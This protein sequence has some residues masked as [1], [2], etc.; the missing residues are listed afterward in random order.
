MTFPFIEFRDGRNSFALLCPVCGA[1]GELG[2]HS[3]KTVQLIPCP[4]ECGAYF[5]QRRQYGIFGKPT[6]ECV[7]G[8]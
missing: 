8:E 7:L 4:N 6:L 2:I 3:H 5:M 1:E